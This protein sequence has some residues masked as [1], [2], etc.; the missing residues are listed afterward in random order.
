MAR[1]L[2]CLILAAGKG[3][4]MKSDLAK[5]LHPIAGKPMLDH[6]LDTCAALKP[7]KIVTVISPDNPQL[8][9]ALEGRS[10]IAIQEVAN[11]TGGA[12]L[13]A[14]MHLNNFD[15]D[16][17]ILYG[18]TPLIQKDTLEVMM[19]TRAA[20]PEAGLVF[21]AFTPDNPTGFGRMVLDSD[22]TLERIVEEK[23]ASE[24]ERKINL[25]NGGV[26]CA[27]GSR[28]FGWLSQI[29]NDNAQGE[30][31]L[32]D[33]PEIARR[34]NCITRIAEISEDEI[35]GVNSRVDQAHVEKLMQ[36][37]L[38]IQLMENGVTLIDPDTVYL[39]AT[40]DIAA[41]VTI[42]PNVVI[43]E[44]VTIESGVVIHAFSHLE[45]CVVRQNASI[46]P[47]ARLRPNADVGEDAVIGNFVEL[48]STTIGKGSKAK[49]FS[50]LGNTTLGEYSNIGAGTMTANYDGYD[51]SETV[52]GD[53]VSTGIHAS[54]VA[55]VT[56]NDG[57]ITAAGSTITV[58]VEA[59]SLAIERNKQINIKGWA[60]E[61]RTIKE[62]KK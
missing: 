11:G 46:G 36:Y 1:K 39:S 20:A 8:E 55:P 17:V 35:T 3:S 62:Q 53:R 58:D 21:S 14:Q 41:D 2:A 4:R 10:E 32:V 19:T 42:H 9:D 25:C 23:D 47:Y 40:A 48:K 37:R 18:D 34:E 15:G 59:D 56:I 33:L 54:I 45:N 38:R 26:V 7:E 29:S 49:H 24:D 51:K 50:Y 27:D 16:V 28:L 61:F 57:A 30:Y 43:G 22:G 13:A 12:A 5:P 52:I 60:K 6:I 44:D 31:Y